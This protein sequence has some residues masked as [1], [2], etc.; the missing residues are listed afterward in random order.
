MFIFSP[1]QT[2]F[3]FPARLVV[4]EVK[5]VLSGSY[6]EANTVQERCGTVP[7]CYAN[8]AAFDT[9]PIGTETP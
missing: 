7:G 6:M 8:S 3:N 1:V 9:L 5:S 4:P 2:D